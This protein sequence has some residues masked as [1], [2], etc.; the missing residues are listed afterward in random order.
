MNIIAI[1]Y[2]TL[3]TFLSGIVLT[4]YSKI[5]RLITNMLI[6]IDGYSIGYIMAK[7]ILGVVYLCLAVTL[8]R[9]VKTKMDNSIHAQSNIIRI[10]K[11]LICLIGIILISQAV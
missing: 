1:F 9:L 3:I 5:E 8:Y 2:A 11:T 7:I 10:K 6:S 4:N